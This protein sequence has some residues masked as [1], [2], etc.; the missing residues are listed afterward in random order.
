MKKECLALLVVLIACDG[1]VDGPD[2]SV[3]H[4]LAV[5]AGESMMC[6]D[7]RHFRI[8]NKGTR[9]AFAVVLQQSIDQAM[10]EPALRIHPGPDPGESVLA[11]VC[12][13]DQPAADWCVEA[14]LQ[15]L[16]SSDPQDHNSLDNRWCSLST[17][18]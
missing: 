3:R 7:P 8:S 17:K 10:V 12:A 1:S 9:G 16:Q 4:E 11:L 15:S 14:H 2:L 13:P 5:T 18:P 6:A